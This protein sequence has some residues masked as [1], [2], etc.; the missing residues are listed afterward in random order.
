M[1][2]S[3]LAIAFELAEGINAMDRIFE[4]VPFRAPDNKI[5]EGCFMLVF[6]V[7]LKARARPADDVRLYLPRA[8][9]ACRNG[10]KRVHL[11]SRHVDGALISELFTHQ[12]VGTMVTQDSI[13]QIREAR[14][15]DV[16]G[17]LGLIQPLEEQGILVRRPRELIEMEIDR[18]TVLDHDRMIVGC[19]ALDRKSTRL[20]SSH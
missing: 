12:G 3:D 13:E 4:W 10:V 5:L 15:D 18:F 7:L 11:I 8:V 19:A 9:R 16:G 1:C 6:F 14:I 2:S 20:N 17:I